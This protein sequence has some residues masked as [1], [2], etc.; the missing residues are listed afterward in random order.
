VPQPEV[1]R[2]AAAINWTLRVIDHLNQPS[3]ALHP[4]I[5]KP[6]GVELEGPQFVVESDM[7]VCRPLPAESLFRNES[8]MTGAAKESPS[9][10]HGPPVA[11]RASHQTGTIK[12][13][14]WCR[15][16]RLVRN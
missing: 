10:R 7:W 6:V 11:I 12:K 1:E 14:G 8:R 3:K 13:L 5:K 9:S 2:H 4:R 16:A 15:L